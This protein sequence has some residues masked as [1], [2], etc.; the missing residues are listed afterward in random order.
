VR[1]P[2]PLAIAALVALVLLALATALWLPCPG[3]GLEL[4]GVTLAGCP[5][6]L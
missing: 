3:R 2:V 1:I 6:R 5:T 4:G